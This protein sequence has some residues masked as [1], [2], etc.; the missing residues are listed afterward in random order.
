MIQAELLFLHA[1]AA[2]TCSIIF[3]SITEIFQMVTELQARN[4]FNIW[5]RGD[6]SKMK[7]AELLF[8]HLTLLVG[9]LYNP[10]KYH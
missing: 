1:T 4:E 9:L 5:L 7:K 6:N 8:L 10:T 3:P 2:V